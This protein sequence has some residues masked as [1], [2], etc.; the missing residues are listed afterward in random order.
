MVR[1]RAFAC[2]AEGRG[3]KAPGRTGRIPRNEQRP[4]GG[5]D[6]WRI[7]SYAANHVAHRCSVLQ[8]IFF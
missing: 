7:P 8:R 1:A 2:K 3:A 4:P 5:H 6:T